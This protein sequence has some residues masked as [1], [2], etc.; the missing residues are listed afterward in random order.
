MQLNLPAVVYG[1]VTA[2]LAAEIDFVQI[3][4]KIIV[5]VRR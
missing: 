2:G 4:P 3:G 5:F 1:A